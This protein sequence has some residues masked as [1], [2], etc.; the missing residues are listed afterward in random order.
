[1]RKRKE[2]K[3]KALKELN[4]IHRSLRIL[5][6]ETARSRCAYECAMDVVGEQIEIIRNVILLVK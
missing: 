4:D 1:M 3:K 2:T 5:L 6:K